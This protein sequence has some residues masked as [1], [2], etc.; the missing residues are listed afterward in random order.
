MIAYT[1]NWRTYGAGEND[2]PDWFGLTNYKSPDMWQRCPVCEGV[3]TIPYSSTHMAEVEC[4]V[5]KGRGIISTITGL[6]P[7]A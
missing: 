2:K 6:P 3:G 5:C 1:D 4:H 7:Q